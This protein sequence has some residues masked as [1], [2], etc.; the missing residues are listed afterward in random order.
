MTAPCSNPVYRRGHDLGGCLHQA[1][2]WGGQFRAAVIERLLAVLDLV[3]LHLLQ[4]R[5]RPAV[6]SRYLLEVLIEMSLDLTLRLGDEAQAPFVTGDAG[7]GKTLW[8]YDNWQCPCPIA[9]PAVTVALVVTGWGLAD[10]YFVLPYTIGNYLAPLLNTPV[11]DTDSAAFLEAEL[12]VKE[13]IDGFLSSKGTRTVDDFHRKLGRIVWDYCGMERSQ[14]GLEK[15]LSEIPALREEFHADVRVPGSGD[16]VNSSLEKVGRVSDFFELAELMC[17]DAL[18]REESCGAHFREDHQTSEGEAKR[19]D[20]VFTHVSA[21][22]FT[23]VGATPKLHKEPLTFE[24][25]KPATRS[26]K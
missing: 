8:T 16:T 6:V 7:S 22:E 10:G 5:A 11:P 12:E 13:R 2:N 24:N 3:G 26:Y 25:V 19:N 20:D 4:D 23:G 15:A 9:R 17:L 14:A 18:D 21:W 1:T